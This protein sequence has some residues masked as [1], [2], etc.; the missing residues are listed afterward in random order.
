MGFLPWPRAAWLRAPPGGI[1]RP[2]ADSVQLAPGVTGAQQALLCDPQ[3]SGGLLVACSP[4]AVGDV[5]K[6]FAQQG[7]EGAAVIGSMKAGLPR[8]SVEV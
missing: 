2:T 1:G 4:D 7:F 3:T 5:M 6:T 8:V